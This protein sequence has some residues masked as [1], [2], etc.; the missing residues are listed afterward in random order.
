MDNTDLYDLPLPSSVPVKG[1]SGVRMVKEKPQERV[2]EG[3]KNEVGIGELVMDGLG[4]REKR[5]E[6]SCWYVV[7]ELMVATTATSLGFDFIPNP[8]IMALPEYPSSAINVKPK[9]NPSNATP[10]AATPNTPA[11]I[12]TQP[13]E[14]DDDWDHITEFQENKRPTVKGDE[15]DGDII[16]LGEIELEEVVAVKDKSDVKGKGGK[17]KKEKTYAGAVRTA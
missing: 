16:I 5:G 10:L 7:K 4:R 1:L 17:L 2:V 9:L 12:P 11:L 14:E 6:S 8:S 15:D 13:E 3:R